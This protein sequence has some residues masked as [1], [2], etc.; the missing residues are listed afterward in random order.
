MPLRSSQPLRSAWPRQRSAATVPPQQAARAH[1]PVEPR[2]RHLS[3]LLRALDERKRL[4][5]CVEEE[6]HTRCPVMHMRGRAWG[7]AA[8]AAACNEHGSAPP[9]VQDAPRT[10]GDRVLAQALHKHAL[11]GVLL[12]AW[13]SNSQG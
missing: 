8:G 9:A 4:A 1:P 10:T 3:S 5:L 6:Q 12:H 2:R 11:Y 7:R 13:V